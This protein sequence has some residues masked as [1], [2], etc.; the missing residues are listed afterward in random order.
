MGRPA[1]IRMTL[2]F[3][4]LTKGNLTEPVITVETEIT[5]KLPKPEGHR[6]LFYI[7]GEGNPTTQQQRQRELGLTVAGAAESKRE[8]KTA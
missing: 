3:A 8:E 1:S 7:D 5:T 6:A 2:D 4:A